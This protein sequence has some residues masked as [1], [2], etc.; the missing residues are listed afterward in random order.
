MRYSLKTG[1]ISKLS[2][3]CLAVMVFS[4]GTLSEEA[5]ALDEASSGAVGRLIESGDFSGKLGESQFLY[6]PAGVTAR[7]ILLIGGGQRSK[8]GAVNCIKALT[9]A[10][11][12]LARSKTASAHF[13]LADIEVS[14]RDANWLAARL[15]QLTEDASYRYDET[16]SKKDPGVTLKSVSISPPSGAVRKSLSEALKTGAAVGRGVNKAK[17]LGDLPGNICTPSPLH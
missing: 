15:A 13:G 3:D 5:G 16:K 14:D 10:L 6:S 8:F 17:Y 12:A 4:R 7:R 9:P 11:K 1:D 2:V